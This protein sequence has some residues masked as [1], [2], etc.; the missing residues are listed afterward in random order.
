M[1]ETPRTAHQTG[2]D[3]ILEVREVQTASFF[4]ALSDKDAHLATQGIEEVNLE[5]GQVLFRQDDP[6]DSMFF[7]VYGQLEVR[8]RVPGNEDRVVSVVGPNSIIGE[9]SLLLDEPRAA[10]V[11]ALGQV[12]LWEVGRQKFQEALSWNER[13]ANQFLF[14]MAQ[15][16]ARRLGTMNREIVDMMAKRQT[17][18]PDAAAPAEL[19]QMFQNMFANL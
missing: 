17:S 11:V 5:A 2:A 3:N 8:L 19:E 15:I 6:G 4:K 9:M 16:L 13:W 7:V 12:Q 18:A 14:Y 10:T 1:S